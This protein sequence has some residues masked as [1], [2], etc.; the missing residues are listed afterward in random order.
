MMKMVLVMKTRQ[1]DLDPVPVYAGHGCHS[2]QTEA[3]VEMS[4][5]DAALRAHG[6]AENFSDRM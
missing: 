3:V 5:V 6:P 1:Q 4:L 2:V